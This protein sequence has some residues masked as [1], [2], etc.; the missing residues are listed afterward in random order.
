MRSYDNNVFPDCVSLTFS[1]SS[2]DLKDGFF[3]VKI[4]YGSQKEFSCVYR[5][6][7]S[8]KAKHKAN[9]EIVKHYLPIAT[10]GTPVIALPAI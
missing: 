7:V 9:R 2:F 4:I 5:Y 8:T 3:F 10:H 6:L 1:Y